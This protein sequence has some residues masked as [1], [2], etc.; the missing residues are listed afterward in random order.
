VVGGFWRKRQGLLWSLENFRGFFWIFGGFRVVYDLF[1]NI[2]RKPRALL[3]FLQT[4][5]DCG[6]ILDKYRG[7]GT[8][9]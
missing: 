1:V 4:S 9:L 7:F 8:N 3:E 5:K 6:K 2:F